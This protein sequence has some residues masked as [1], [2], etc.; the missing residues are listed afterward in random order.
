MIIIVLI[1]IVWITI[2]ISVGTVVGSMLVDIQAGEIVAVGTYGRR[3]S[4]MKRE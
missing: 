4:E 3:R 2:Q 1:I